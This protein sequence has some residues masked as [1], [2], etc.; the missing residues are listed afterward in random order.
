MAGYEVTWSD[1]PQR[2]SFKP[3]LFDGF[4]ASFSKVTAAYIF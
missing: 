1:F 2:W 3:A 4:P